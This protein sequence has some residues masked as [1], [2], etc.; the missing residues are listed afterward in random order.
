LDEAHF[1]IKPYRVRG[2]FLK[3]SK[4]TVDTTYAK[5]RISVFGALSKDELFTQLT[6]EKCDNKTYLTFLKALLRNH[7]KIVIVVD[8]SK[9][10]F[11]KEHVQKFYKENED[12]LKVI[13]LPPY[14]PELSPIEQTW[15]K[16]KKWLA[17][18]IWGRKEEFETELLN[19]LNSPSTRVK[20]FD[21][22]VP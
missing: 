12:C 19:A 21:Y 15:K 16:T 2:W 5:G 20:M 3:G 22:F 11:E 1:R 18:A 10:H 13:Q 8:G 6:E 9:Y 4:A 14:S 7:G 17:I